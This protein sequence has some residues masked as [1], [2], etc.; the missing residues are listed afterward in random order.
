MTALFFAFTVFAHDHSLL[1]GTW[2]LA[3]A[4]SDFAGQP[5]MQSGTI[6][7]HDRDGVIIIERSFVYD[8]GTETVFYSDSIGTENRATIHNGKDHAIRRDYSR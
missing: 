2:T 1:N 7:I 8:G 3:P 5:V 4:R 6:T